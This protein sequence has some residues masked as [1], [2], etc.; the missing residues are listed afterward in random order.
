MF[1]NVLFP[2]ADELLKPK[3]YQLDPQD[4]SKTRLRASTMLCKV[5]IHCEVRDNHKNADI[6]RLWSRILE[7]LDQFIMA[8]ASEQLVCTATN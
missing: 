6:Q 7:L 8:E 5:F 4:M 3:V 1:D 2:L